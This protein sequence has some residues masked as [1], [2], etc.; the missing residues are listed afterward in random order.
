MNMDFGRVVTAMVT[1]FNA[2]ESINYEEA[3]K[4]AK[5]LVE[6]GSDS[7]VV[8]GT[9]GESPTL[10]H[11]EDLLLYKTVIAAVNGKAKVIAGTGSN[12]TKT[13]I[14]YTQKAKNLGVDGVLLVCPYY[15]KPTQEGLYQ[16]FKA[17]AENCNVP[18][19]LYN[20]P[21]RTAVNMLPETTAKL[22]KIENIVCIK[23]AAGDLKQVEEIKKLVSKDF[24]IYSG[25]DALTLEILKRGG[26]GIVS[27][28]AHLIGKEI[29]QMV[30]LFE[31]G[32]VQEAAKIDQKY[33]ALYKAI[34]I[35]TNPSPIKAA[36]NLL[37]WKVGGTRLP[38]T[39]LS[40]EQLAIL[41]ANMQEVGL[42]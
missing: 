39:G 14:E 38:L 5:Y 19:M 18:I 34:F 28:A 16:H 40:V 6:N 22:S 3:A 8:T 12:S 32:Q 41:K 13:T 20:I 21:G 42:L 15:N 26:K 25:D 1:P 30:Q 27:V 10:T 17:V 23:E 31:K 2:D 7:L 29:N 33:Q 24:A 35:S 9:T 37:G 4:L 36:L 11:E